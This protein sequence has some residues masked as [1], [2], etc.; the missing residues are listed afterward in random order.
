[1]LDVT[2]IT[3]PVKVLETRSKRKHNL[4]SVPVHVDTETSKHI[5]Y[6]EKGNVTTCYGWIYLYGIEFAG[7]YG[8][9]RKPSELIQDLELIRNNFGCTADGVHLVVYIHNLS[10]DVQYLK[11]FLLARYGGDYDLL[12]IAPHRFITF[13]IDAF[14]FRC[15]LKLSNRRLAK[16]ANDLEVENRKAEGEIDYS[17]KH[18]QDEELKPEQYHYMRQDV[19]TLK[20]CVAE[21]MRIFK[22]NLLTIPLTSTGYVRRDVR[23]NYRYERGAVERFRKARL[24]PTTYVLTHCAFSGGLTHG[25]R[26]YAGEIV[27]IEDLRKKYGDNV[28]IRHGDFRSHYPTQQRARILGFPKSKFILYWS[29]RNGK[30]KSIKEIFDYAKK[31][32]MLI[33]IV[34]SHLHIKPGVTLPYAQKCKWIEGK[35]GEWPK[36]KQPIEDNGRLLV[37][38]GAARLVLTELDL[39]ILVDEYNFDYEVLRIYTA[40]RGRVPKY[41]EKT[42]DYYFREKSRL[43]DRVEELRNKNGNDVDIREAKRDLAIVKARLNAIYGCTATN[44]VRT[45]FYMDTNGNWSIEELTPELL[46]DKLDKFYN[47][48]SSCMPF[49]LGLYTTALARYQIWFVVAKVIGYEN[50]LYAD[51]DS[52]FYI[53]TPEVEKRLAEYNAKH[54]EAAEKNGAFVEYDGKKVYYDNFSDEGE[55]I[56][57]FCF[58]HAKAYTYIDQKGMHVT[59]AGVSE[60]NTVSGVTRE[61]ELGSIENFKSGT[62]FRECGGTRSI[63]VEGKPH[64]INEDGHQIE[65]AGACVL[66]NVTK[67]LSLNYQKGNILYDTEYSID[68]C[69]L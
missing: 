46:K 58:L 52:A 37:C 63:Y 42:I 4:L 59:V 20:D 67:T 69:I 32:C 18:Y 9:G 49:Q 34:I 21:Q 36:D 50:F 25:N 17:E 66:E 19:F 14:E 35:I 30:K 68:D 41:L 1:M 53:S 26:F 47:N 61:E 55:N 2:K 6:D 44:P 24:T 54:E 40:T 64:V 38:E 15:S 11:D 22:D 48:Y 5:E 60:K 31:H 7:S 43:K 28:G 10:Y 62:K 65:L 13:R 56:T 39:M 57:D 45:S 27:R 51:T 29:N 23:K 33:E 12:A 3:E 16:W 8:T